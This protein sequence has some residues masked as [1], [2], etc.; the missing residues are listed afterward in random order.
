MRKLWVG[1]VVATLLATWVFGTGARAQ[2]APAPA[3]APAAPAAAAST[4]LSFTKVSVGTSHVCAIV[5]GGE[6]YCWGLNADGE[7]GDG[8]TQN[9][10]HPVKV[11]GLTGLTVT[12]VIAG[13]N[14]TCVR[15]FTNGMRCWGAGTN[16]QLGVSV[17]PAATY[18]LPVS[19]SGLSSG[20]GEIDA[21]GSGTCAEIS[22]AAYCWGSNLTGQMGNGTLGGTVYVPAQV[23]GLSSGISSISIGVLSACALTSNALNGDSIDCWG[24]NNYGQVGGGFTSTSGISL[25]VAVNGLGAFA[26]LNTVN[27]GDS[28]ACTLYSGG[29]VKCWGRGTFGQM[30]NG[31]FTGTNLTP[32]SVSSL[33]LAS[34]ISTGWYSA[35]ARTSAGAAYCWGHGINGQLGNGAFNDSNVP[36]LV[37]GLNSGVLQVS[38][39][40]ATAC[41]VL[42]GGRLKCWGNNQ[43]GQLGDGTTSDSAV[44]L[45]VPSVFTYLPIIRR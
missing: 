8:T 41:A 19:V 38:V 22:G 2:Q 21:G 43:F 12:D 33:P 17:S 1:L 20:I 4:P 28:Y 11:L 45:S 27:V 31:S 42:S 14:H 30:G 10:P 5:S 23:S 34:Q 9:R 35:C 32:V 13:N 37:S 3:A 40:F 36:V 15:F 39:G 7:L 16:G 44:P 6:V 26:S 29:S 25:P 18:S 24:Y